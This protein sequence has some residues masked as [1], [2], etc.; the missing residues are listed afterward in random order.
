MFFIRLV[1]AVG[2]FMCNT[3]E[4]VYNIK[5]PGDILFYGF[6]MTIVPGI[7]AYLVF[8]YIV[9]PH[10]TSEIAQEIEKKAYFDRRMEI[11]QKAIETREALLARHE[12]Q[13][14]RDSRSYLHNLFIDI[15]NSISI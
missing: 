6:S 10:N 9:D 15:S 2:E 3:C 5:T 1:E 14:A 13:L 4:Y 8:K 11:K 7:S 12:A